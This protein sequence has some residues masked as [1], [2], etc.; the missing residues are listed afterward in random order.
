MK[1]KIINITCASIVMTGEK[2]DNGYKINNKATDLHKTWY[3]NTAIIEKEWITDD[4][5]NSFGDIEKGF[6]NSLGLVQK[7]NRI[8]GPIKGSDAEL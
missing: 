7:E 5:K 2:N 3:L 4:D 6:A 1:L 8:S